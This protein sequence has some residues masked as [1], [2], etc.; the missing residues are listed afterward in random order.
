MK[1]GEY[2][3][4]KVVKN[5]DFG[6]YL[7]G[8]E[9]GEILLPSRYITEPLEPGDEILVFIYRDSEDRLIATTEHPYVT[10]GQV[11][12]LEVRAITTNGAFLDWGLPKDLLLPYSEQTFKVREGMVVPVYVYLDQKTRRVA[13]SARL[14]H[15]IGN[16]IPEDL[17]P[18]DKVTAIVL[19]KTDIG[20]RAV[21]NDL[22]WGMVYDDRVYGPVEVGVPVDAWVERVRD[23]GKID[24]LLQPAGEARIEPLAQKIMQALD[25]AGGSLPL[26]DGSSPEVIKERFA[27]S[28][29]DFKKALGSLYKQHL[30]TIEPESITRT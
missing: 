16:V 29:K 18:G 20:Y 8:G 25:Q 17:R 23:D 12:F 28:K 6:A 26:G 19:K 24:L 4:L 2:N 7:D 27:C 9:D 1:I 30:I 3:R 10:V 5:V 22:Y 11:A 13:A 15:F 14:E 21:V